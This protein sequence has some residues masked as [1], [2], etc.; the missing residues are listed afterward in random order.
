MHTTHLDD[1]SLGH[2]LAVLGDDLE[3][4]ISI[5]AF[6]LLRVSQD[7]GKSLCKTFLLEISCLSQV[8]QCGLMTSSTDDN[9]MYLL[10]PL[11][12]V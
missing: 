10:N 8:D 9:D 2:D 7:V 12:Q 5:L 11:T 6:L 3:R 4:L 1:G